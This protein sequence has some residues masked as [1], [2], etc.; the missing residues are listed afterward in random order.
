MVS[1]AWC[2][3][4]NNPTADDPKLL[5]ACPISKYIC[6]GLETGES[7]TP[8]FQGYLELSKP[9]RISGI[10]KLEGPFARM[11]LESR[12]GSR[13]EARNYCMKG[14]Q[15]HDEWS[16]F[17]PDGPNF[18]L[19]AAFFEFGSWEHSQGH[20]NDLDKAR[21]LA[22]EGGMRA[23][24]ER[25]SAQQIQVAREFLTYHEE[26]RDW[27]PTIIWLWGPSGIGK[28]LTARNFT[29]DMDVFV[30][31]SGTKWW[32]GYD[33]Q[34]AVIIDDFRDSWWSLTEMLS[35]L[36]RYEKRVEIK[37]GWR[38]FKPKVIVITS[39][40]PPSACYANIGECKAQLARR[41]NITLELA[42]GDQKK[43]PLVE[44]SCNEV[45]VTK[46]QEVILGPIGAGPLATFNLEEIIH[47]FLE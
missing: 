25:C 1:R 24:T 43:A 45:S 8:H 19:N 34:E 3:T 30:K 7:G 40:R 41:I 13:D 46:S 35:L 17:G 26:P 22:L 29:H 21:T 11:H 32:D 14:E 27:A 31:N 36:D 23:V 10:K 9:V 16:E 6:W 38:Q 18:G 28:S 47:D 2:W 20:R 44:T 39:I 15:S 37:G 4:L 5:E 12:R 42:S 33:G